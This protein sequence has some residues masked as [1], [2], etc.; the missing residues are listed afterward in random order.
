[1]YIFTNLESQKFYDTIQHDCISVPSELDKAFCS[2]LGSE[3]SSDDEF[4]DANE[5]IS[6]DHVEMS[7]MDLREV[8]IHPN[9]INVTLQEAPLELTVDLPIQDE[10]QQ[11]AP[12]CILRE[13]LQAIESD[14]KAEG[15]E[16]FGDNNSALREESSTTSM[17]S[18]EKWLHEQTE[19]AAAVLD[20]ALA[21]MPKT[22]KVLSESTLDSYAFGE[23]PELNGDIS[24]LREELE[25][26]TALYDEGDI[27]L[28]AAG[29][30]S[31]QR[32]KNMENEVLEIQMVDN[33]ES[34][35]AQQ[36][37]T[38]IM[39]RHQISRYMWI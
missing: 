16:I 22:P 25:T 31:A 6:D 26:A 33:H 38:N 37:F 19:R 23:T 2:D 17:D 12:I 15:S 13:F 28:D 32:E 39:G 8:E 21:S 27:N 5:S 3:S 35:L 20:E 1:M 34:R 10:N 29:P 36:S 7:T 14:D 11:S 4:F 9:D 24:S 30:K 18:Y